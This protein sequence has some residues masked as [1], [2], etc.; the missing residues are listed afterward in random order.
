MSEHMW[1]VTR[2]KPSRA[3]ARKWDRVCREAGG[4]GFVETSNAPG[5]LGWFAGPNRGHPFDRELERRVA[6]A[7]RGGAR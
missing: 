7:I 4:Y 1:G 3:T 6:E 5:Y 2:E